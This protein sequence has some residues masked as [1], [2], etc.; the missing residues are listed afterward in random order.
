M[1]NQPSEE[2]KQ[3]VA[4]YQYVIE[5]GIKSGDVLEI[6]KMAE[7]LRPLEIESP[8]QES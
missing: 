1:E 3:V 4:D 7:S 8:R 5:N 6:L 2:L